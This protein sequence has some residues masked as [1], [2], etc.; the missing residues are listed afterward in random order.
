MGSG[1]QGRAGN[2]QLSLGNRSVPTISPESFGIAPVSS[3]TSDPTATYGAVNTPGSNSGS[4][5]PT[6]KPCL[7][8]PPGLSWLS[9]LPQCRV[10]CMLEDGDDEGEEPREC[11]AKRTVGVLI[12]SLLPPSSMTRAAARRIGGWWPGTS[13][14]LSAG[15]DTAAS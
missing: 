14:L 9:I 12:L 1:E 7:H 2:P 3:S 10:T 6:G 8:Q 4:V 11:L 5:S 13:R 15:E